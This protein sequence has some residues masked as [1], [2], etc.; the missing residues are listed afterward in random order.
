MIRFAAVVFFAAC[1]LVACRSSRHRPSIAAGS[2]AP[3]ATSQQPTGLAITPSSVAIPCIRIAL[4]HGQDHRGWRPGQ[5]PTRSSIKEGQVL[6]G[7]PAGAGGAGRWRGCQ[8]DRRDLCR[9]AFAG[10]PVVAAVASQFGFVISSANR[11]GKGHIR[12]K[13][14]RV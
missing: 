6:R 7:D 10:S 13:L 2:A 14:M 3:G 4:E 1:W 11:V 5:L 12:T 9:G 8:T